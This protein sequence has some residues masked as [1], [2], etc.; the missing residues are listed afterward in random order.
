MALGASP[1]KHCMLIVL[2]TR[3]RPELVTTIAILY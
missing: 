1:I 3:V 2:K